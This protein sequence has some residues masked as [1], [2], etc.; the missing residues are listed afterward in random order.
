MIRSRCDRVIL[1]GHDDEEAERGSLH[2]YART[3]PAEATGQATVRVDE[4]VLRERRA[5][6]T[7]GFVRADRHVSGGPALPQCSTGAAGGTAREAWGTRQRAVVRVD[8]PHLG[9]GPAPGL[10]GGGMAAAHEPSDSHSGRHAPGE[11]LVRM[12]VGGGGIS[13]SAEDRLRDR[14]TANAGRITSRTRHRGRQRGGPAA[15]ATARSC[16]S[17]GRP[18]PPCR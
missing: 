14:E 1:L 10:R 6:Q 4:D 8:R 13:Q 12:A 2:A 16:A 5:G 18:H 3:L 11:E 17:S 15:A 7:S 9:T